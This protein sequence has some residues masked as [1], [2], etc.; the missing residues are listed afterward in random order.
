MHAWMQAWF[1][2]WG[3]GEAAAASASL[4][5]FVLGALLLAWLADRI[6]KLYLVRL[7]HYLTGRTNTTWDDALGEHGVFRRIAQL[8]PAVVLF[9]T[10]SAFGET[11]QDWVERGALVY[12][13]VV[14]ALAM[15]ALLQAGLSIYQRSPISQERPVQGYVQ[16]FRILLFTVAAIF[17]VSTLLDEEPWGLLTG[18]GALSAILLLVFRDTILGFVASVQLATNDMVRRGDWIEMPAFGADGDVL[19]VSLHTVKVQNWDKTISTIPTAALITNSFKNWRGMSESGGRRI[20]RAV[21]IDMNTIRFCDD[22]LL[23]R[24]ERFDA[25]RDY[26]HGKREEL[27]RS[28]AGV[29]GGAERINARRLT[30]VGTFRAYL[31]AYLRAHPKIHDGLTFLVRQLPPS[32]R[33]LPIELYV[34]SNDQE[35]A[36]Y[37]A[38]Q[39]DI[40]DHILAVL[41]EFE[42]RAYQSPSG[43]D[44]EATARVVAAGGAEGSG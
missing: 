13:I 16:L 38:I 7:A 14:T 21:Y 28:N 34:F 36:S 15:S 39:A 31:I 33:G 4:A 42:L 19:E 37:E 11:A 18:L 26:V 10:G 35:W 32:D 41:P 43:H 27:T 3:L 17:V 30:N 2:T 44:L 8:A 24:F 20:K 25:I 6:A 5:A 40:F 1:E 12:M 22:D 23:R 29:D 9:T